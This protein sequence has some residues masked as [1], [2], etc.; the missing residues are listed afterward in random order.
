MQWRLL[1]N[2]TLSC[3]LTDLIAVSKSSQWSR[4]NRGFTNVSHG[5]LVAIYNRHIHCA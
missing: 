2:P 4:S 5:T 3:T 1:A